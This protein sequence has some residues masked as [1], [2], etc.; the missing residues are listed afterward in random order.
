MIPHLRGFWGQ[1]I[2]WES[3]FGDQRSTL[4]L[5]VT[6]RSFEAHFRPFSGLTP[7][8]DIIKRFNKIFGYIL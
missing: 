1:G 2:Q 5:K 7:F 8:F 6:K 3:Y 4:A